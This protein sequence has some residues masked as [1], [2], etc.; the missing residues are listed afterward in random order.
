VAIRQKRAIGGTCGHSNLGLERGH[1]TLTVL[2]KGG[3]I[4]S[5]PLAPTLGHAQSI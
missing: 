3:K 4:V 1:R 2:R 5:I